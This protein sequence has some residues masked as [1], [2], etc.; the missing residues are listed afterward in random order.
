MNGANEQ[1]RRRF[2]PRPLFFHD[3]GQPNH[4]KRGWIFRLVG[5]I[6]PMPFE[7]RPVLRGRLDRHH[8]AL[9]GDRPRGR[10][11][12]VS[13][14]GAHVPT[15]SPG[16]SSAAKVLTRRCSKVPWTYPRPAV[17]RLHFS[18]ALIPERMRTGMCSGRRCVESIAEGASSVCCDELKVATQSRVSQPGGM[19]RFRSKLCL[20]RR[21]RNR[22]RHRGRAGIGARFDFRNGEPQARR[23]VRR[24][25]GIA[26]STSLIARG[27]VCSSPS[28]RVV[29]RRRS[30]GRGRPVPRLRAG[31]MASAFAPCRRATRIPSV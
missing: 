30:R 15:T 31:M 27:R 3:R 19:S 5:L 13:L 22:T 8:V 25:Q 24:N 1:G 6:P 11:R 29:R 10:E 4:R 7:R 21:F 20:K 17:A 28:A 14:V 18:P 26:A 23:R 12:H 16:R 9:G 2:R